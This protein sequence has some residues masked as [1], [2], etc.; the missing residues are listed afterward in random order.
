M[1]QK[2]LAHETK[3]HQRRGKVMENATAVVKEKEA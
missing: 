3:R 2:K 1:Q